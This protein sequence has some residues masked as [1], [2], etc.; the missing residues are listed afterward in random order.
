MLCL[1]LQGN[2][3]SLTQVPGVHL[4]SRL[5]EWNFQEICWT[6]IN[7]FTHSKWEEKG[8]CLCKQSRG[9]YPP[10]NRC[11]FL[12]IHVCSAKCQ[13]FF[14]EL[15][16]SL[17]LYLSNYLNTECSAWFQRA[18]TL[19]KKGKTNSVGNEVSRWTERNSG[20]LLEALDIQQTTM[21]FFL[22]CFFSL[23]YVIMAIVSF[24]TTV[25]CFLTLPCTGNEENSN[26]VPDATD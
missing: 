6:I 15:N 23:F 12:K 4:A 17:P 1:T 7:K 24:R 11:L 3:E 22:F 13:C 18:I 19:S 21:F 5:P 14:I 10:H 8:Y 20:L 9:E 2:S 26:M 16:N 25:C